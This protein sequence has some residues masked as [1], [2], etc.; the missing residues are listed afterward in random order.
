MCDR[1]EPPAASAQ[2]SGGSGGGGGGGGPGNAWL[3][4]AAGT[5]AAGAPATAT[6]R[7]MPARPSSCSRHRRLCCRNSHPHRIGGMLA[8]QHIVRFGKSLGCCRPAL[9]AQAQILKPCWPQPS[10]AGCG[11]H[12]RRMTISERLLLHETAAP[13]KRAHDLL[14]LPCAHLRVVN[15]DGVPAWLQHHRV[16]HLVSEKSVP[17]CG[18]L[19]EDES[20]TI[21]NRL[22]PTNGA[23]PSIR[24]CVVSSW[25]NRHR[26]LQS[27]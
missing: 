6:L 24:P 21:R 23:Q 25:R 12:C 5:T 3:N 19:P 17:A 9:L 18:G 22:I 13:Q 14:K 11:S 16:G 4:Q 26:P 8:M 7:T 20:E 15:P 10:D 27:P 1:V 2:R